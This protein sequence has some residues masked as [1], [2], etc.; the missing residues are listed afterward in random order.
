MDEY[1]SFAANYDEFMELLGYGT[2]VAVRFRQLIL[3]KYRT[4]QLCIHNKR[5]GQ[6]FVQYLGIK[7]DDFV[8]FLHEAAFP[9]FLV[10]HVDRSDY[11]IVN[12]ITLVYDLVTMR[13]VRGSFYGML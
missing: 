7:K 1:D 5:A 3:S 4:D 10:K 12:E 8:S 2:T 11:R 9:K 6:I 13:V